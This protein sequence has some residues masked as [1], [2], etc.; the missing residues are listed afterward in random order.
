MRQRQT[1]GEIGQRRPRLVVGIDSKGFCLRLLRALA[2]ERRAAPAG[3]PP[4][5]LGHYAAPSVG[6]FRDAARLAELPGGAQRALQAAKEEASKH[7]LV[8]RQPVPWTG[9]R[10][11]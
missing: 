1:L 8:F 2:G 4:G 7:G 9:P 10:R 5:S 6:A 3:A 11:R